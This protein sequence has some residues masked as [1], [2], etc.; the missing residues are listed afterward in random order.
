M[1][2]S[3]DQS[4]T[5]RWL[6]IALVLSLAINA[7]IVGTIATRIID[8]RSFRR[9]NPP[10]V[11]DA[12]ADSNRLLRGVHKERRDELRRIVRDY[13][14]KLKPHRDALDEARNA[15]AD[16]VAADPFDLPRVE[17]ALKAIQDVRAD[18]RDTGRGLTIDL[19]AAMTPT[20]RKELAERMDRRKKT[21]TKAE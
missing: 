5:I 7:F 9:P 4:G 17:A 12:L 6:G 2:G 8:I 18:M 10:P 15:L 20:E 16:A 14:P 1:T 19:I 11:V 3:G 21:R 13:R